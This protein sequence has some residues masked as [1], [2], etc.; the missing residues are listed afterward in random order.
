MPN[1]SPRKRGTPD[2]VVV[3]A[4]ALVSIVLLI[5][6]C[7]GAAFVFVFDKPINTKW[8]RARSDMAEI[9]KALN[10]YALDH[11][12]A[13]PPDLAVLSTTYSP[14]GIHKDPFSKGDYEYKRTPTG[15]TLTCLGKD[16]AI[17]GADVPDRDIIF[18]ETGQR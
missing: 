1:D 10:R 3:P 17:G 8:D 12:G 6:L 18:D 4:A 11:A 2:K 15:F 16:L 7:G 13:Y 14:S 9:T 5:S